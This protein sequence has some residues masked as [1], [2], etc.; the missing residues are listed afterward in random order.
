MTEMTNA[1]PPAM[2]DGVRRMSG[3]RR[4][5]TFGGLLAALALIWV[6]TRYGAAPAMVPLYSGVDL[7]EVSGMTDALQ[8]AGIRFELAGGGTTIMVDESSAARARVALAKVGLPSRGGQRGNEIFDQPSFGLTADE[9]RTRE[10]LALEGE[11]SR[12]IGELDGVERATVHLALP[13]ESPLR[14]LE[15]PAKASVVLTLRPGRSFGSEAVQGITYIVSH[16]V[17]Q[18]PSDQVAVLD[19]EGHVLST[20]N[21]GSMAGLTTRQLEMQRSVEEYLARN[22]ERI[23]ATA[24]G[25]GEARVQVAAKLNFEQVD[26]TVET[27]NPDGAVLQNE[28]RSEVTGADSLEGGSSTVVNNTYLNSRVVEK[29]AGSVGGIQ[30][31]TVAV[32]LDQKAID[33]ANGTAGGSDLSR[34]EQVVRDAIGIDTTRGDRLTV[35]AIP[36]EPVTVSVDSLHLSVGGGGAEKVLTLVDRFSRPAI[37]LAGIIAALILALKVLRP[38]PAG[39]GPSSLASAGAGGGTIGGAE[40]PALPP[41]QVSQLSATTTRLKTE[42]QAESTARPENTAQVVKTWLAED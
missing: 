10:R 19:S 42:V 18:L 6:V 37:G 29:V 17:P 22:A 32:L 16:A 2:L 7:R 38:G 39:S 41:V 12:T 36:F 23:L 26:K 34:Y 11:L 28:Q 3:T 9:L 33:K 24:L 27:Y 8:K 1:I 13:P 35:T 40:E 4:F 21:D 14:R 30:R 25:A 15:R 20:P 5:L 31:L